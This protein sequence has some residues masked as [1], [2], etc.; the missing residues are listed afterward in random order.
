MGKVTLLSA[1]KALPEAIAGKRP[2]WEEEFAKTDPKAC[3]E[4]LEVVD[5][6]IAGDV[7]VLRKLPTRKKLWEFLSPFVN[8]DRHRAGESGFLTMLRR[9][10]SKYAQ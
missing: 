3:K 4:V 6:F 5:A 9:R 8:S 2:S 10:E 1:A 7:E